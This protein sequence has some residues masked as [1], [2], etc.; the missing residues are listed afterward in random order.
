MAKITEPKRYRNF[1]GKRYKLLMITPSSKS[2]EK[3][4]A[5]VTDHNFRSVKVMVAG[6]AW[7]HVYERKK[8]KKK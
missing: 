7:Y 4:R 5:I 6:H 2:I 1:N 8:D 3:Q